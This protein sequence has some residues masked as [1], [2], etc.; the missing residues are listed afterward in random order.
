[1][2]P[3]GDGSVAIDIGRREFI[4]VLGGVSVAWPRTARA[5][6][7]GGARRI[8]VLMMYPEED[9]QGELR[10]AV[11]QREIEK[12]GWRVGGNLQVNFHWARVMP[13]GYGLLLRNSGRRWPCFEE[14]FG[15]RSAAKLLT[16]D[17]TRRH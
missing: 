2:I 9:P 3:I 5:Q 17:E 12:T 16:K 10:A 1:M 13:I 4:A 11:F 14:K 15:R 6:Q 8:G 7:P